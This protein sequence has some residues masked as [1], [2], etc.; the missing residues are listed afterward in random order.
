[1]VVKPLQF[2][3][4]GNRGLLQPAIKCHGREY[5]RIIYG[6]DYDQPENLD[7]LRKRGIGQK[8]QLALRETALGE[9]P[10][11]V[12]RDLPGCDCGRVVTRTRAPPICAVSLVAN[13]RS[14]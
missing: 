4:R 5:L 6:P 11:A 13:D 14:V 1:M 10:S 9:C 12:C 8:R 3:Q 2:L 7:R